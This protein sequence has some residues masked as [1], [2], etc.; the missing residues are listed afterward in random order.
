M[1]TE[2]IIDL[3]T[4]GNQLKRTT[5]TGWV[6]R[7]VPNPENV[8]AHSYGVVYTAMILANLIDEPTDLGRLLALATL[9]DLPEALTSDIPVPAWRVLGREHKTAVELTALQTILQETPF[10]DQWFELWQEL[11][12]NESIEAKLVHDADKLE[13]YLQATIYQEQTGNQHLGEFWHT[14]YKANFPQTQAL[15]DTLRQR[16]GQS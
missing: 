11:Q 9:H 13:M 8:A 12:Q 16:V 4:Y 14:P 7:G 3:L 6:Q 2:Q 1:N 5:R 15:Y 10:A